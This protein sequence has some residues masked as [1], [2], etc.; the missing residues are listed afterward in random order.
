MIAKGIKFNNI[1]SWDNLN[2]V[3]SGSEIPP[4]KPK[5]NYVD[6]PGGNGSVDLTEAHGDIV[7]YDRDCKFTFTMNPT[8][9]LSDSAFEEKKTQIS[10]LLNG[11]VFNICLDKDESYYYSGRCE[12]S[13]YLSDKRLRQIVVTAKVKPYKLKVTETEVT[14]T[15]SS[16]VKQVTLKNGRMKVVP[17]IVCSNDNT[18]IIF[19]SKTITLNAGTHNILDIE[20]VK[21]DNILQVQGTGTIKFKYREGDL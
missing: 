14:T 11:K 6:I 4:A 5:T 15:L 7:Y 8:N 2:L 9:D 17:E 18:T 12:V 3:L 13:D 16:T 1:H 20:L 19:N 10:N 21:G